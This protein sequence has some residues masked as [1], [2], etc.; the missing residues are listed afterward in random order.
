MPRSTWL[1]EPLRAEYDRDSFSCSNTALDRYLKEQAAQDFRRGCA[2]PFVLSPGAGQS[3]ILGYYTL[4][5]YGIDTGELPPGVAGKLPRYPLIPATLLGRLAVDKRHQ[6]EGIGECLLMDVLRRSV[7]QSS[8]TASAAV[9]VEAIDERA[10][11]FYRHFG[12]TPFPSITG[13][14]FI[15]T[16][17]VKAL[18]P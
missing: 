14:L 15:L 4:S 10:A 13:R 18:F 7:A 1:V 12:F 6:G 8:R 9:V 2:S 11:Q 3:T 17:T 16:K 5:S